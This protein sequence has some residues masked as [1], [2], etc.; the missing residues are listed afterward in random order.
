MFVILAFDVELAEEMHCRVVIHKKEVSSAMSMCCFSFPAP[1]FEL[2][3]KWFKSILNQN[4]MNH[5]F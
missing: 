2:I 4:K 5:V 1:Y 3:A